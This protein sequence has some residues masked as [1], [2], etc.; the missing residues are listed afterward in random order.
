MEPIKEA[1]N[2]TIKFEEFSKAS[3]REMIRD[4]AANSNQKVSTN[5]ILYAIV[6]K[7]SIEIQNEEFGEDFQLTIPIDVR[8]QIKEYGQKYFGNG[9]MFN[10]INFSTTD[11]KTSD[12]NNIALKIRKN[13]PEVNKEF[14]IEYLNS[15]EEII[16]R[17]QTYRLRPYDPG[18]GC[19]ITNLSKLPATKLD[20]GSG[21]PDFLFPLTVGKNSAAIMADTDNF[22][23]RLA[24]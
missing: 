7:K 20:F 11:I 4:V 8:R 24:Y 23:I 13:M 2:L 14:Y 16:A 9:L 5:D 6:I 17:G 19:L 1:S 22:I 15:L 21:N 18:K 10:E 12:I 3:I